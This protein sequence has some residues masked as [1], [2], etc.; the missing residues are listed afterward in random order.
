MN[1]SNKNND[2][3]P[4]S[5]IK[6]IAILSDFDGT[7]IPVNVLNSIYKKFADPSY[8]VTLER[9]NN[10]EISTQEEMETV[11]ATI[12]ATKLEMESFLNGFELDPGFMDLLDH[13]QQNGIPFVVLSD[14]LKWYIDYIFEQHGVNGVEVL[15]CDIHFEPDGYRFSYPWFDPSTP[16]R[17]TSKPTIVRDYQKRG[18]HVVLLGDGLSDTEAAMAADVIYAKDILL[19]YSKANGIDVREFRNL[20]D[21]Y[22]DLFERGE[23]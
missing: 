2:T 10:G 9:W 12:K 7:I 20:K 21:V 6:K 11:F 18:Y 22:D 3:Y 13:C 1:S 15:A 4:D 8:L 5:G 23:I 19:T 14:G 16:L 17:S